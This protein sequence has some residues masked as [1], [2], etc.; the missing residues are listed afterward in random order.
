MCVYLHVCV[1]T[2]IYL[3]VNVCERECVGGTLKVKKKVSHP[4]GLAGVS[5]SCE[6]C[7]MD[8]ETQTLVLYKKRRR[9]SS[10]H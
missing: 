1:C 6:L 7:G 4:S 3:C 8:A 9:K 2:C 10:S 5:S